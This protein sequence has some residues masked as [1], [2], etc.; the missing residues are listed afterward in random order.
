[1]VRFHVKPNQF[2]EVDSEYIDYLLPFAPHLFRNKQPL[3]SHKPKHEK[4]S[5]FYKSWKLCGYKHQ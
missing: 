4:W 1:M 3:S 2:Y 5:G